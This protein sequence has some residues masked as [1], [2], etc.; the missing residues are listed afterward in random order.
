MN[1][2]IVIS[3]ILASHHTPDQG[4]EPALAV[5]RLSR[6]YG[7]VRLENACDVARRCIQHPRCKQIRT[8]LETGQ[9]H[10]VEESEDLTVK[11]PG[12]ADAEERGYIR[13]ADYWQ[14]EEEAR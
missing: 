9:D 12:E 3:G 2:H 6:R 13:A 1:T 8:L 10:L 11:L 5:L 4:V 14:R 7:G